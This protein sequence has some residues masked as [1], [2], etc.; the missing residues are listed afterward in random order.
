MIVS[1]STYFTLETLKRVSIGYGWS[2]EN[3]ASDPT[4]PCSVPYLTS[5]CGPCDVMGPQVKHM[6]LTIDGSSIQV[7]NVAANQHVVLTSTPK[8]PLR[9]GSTENVPLQNNLSI[10][11][12]AK[13]QVWLFKLEK[14]C[15]H[16]I[17][18]RQYVQSVTCTS[19]SNLIRFPD[20]QKH[21]R[22][23]AELSVDSVTVTFTGEGM[24]MEKASE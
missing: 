1:V 20:I 8:T 5:D 7:F 18:R 19:I 6:P 14:T 21:G 16:Q 17:D 23:Q 10:C 3:L 13:P 22:A 9:M 4:C 15:T 11:L 24:E 2:P 12:F